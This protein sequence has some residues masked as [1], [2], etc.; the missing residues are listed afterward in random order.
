MQR[1]S[2]GPKQGEKEEHIRLRLVRLCAG[3]LVYT[4]G[5]IA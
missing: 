2:Q 3:F 1:Q 4:N 5:K